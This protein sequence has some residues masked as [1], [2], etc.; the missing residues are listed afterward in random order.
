[1]DRRSFLKGAAAT[2][3]AA[4]PLTAFMARLEAKSTPQGVGYGPLIPTPD[5]TTGLNLL[6]LPEGFSYLSF[7]WTGDLMLNGA[8]TPGSH[9]GMAAFNGGGHRVRLV[10]NHE[11]G[12]RHTLQRRCVRSAAS[13]GRPRSS[14]M[15]R[16][17]VHQRVRQPERHDPQLR[18]WSDAM[19]HL[20]HV[21]R[22]VRSTRRGQA[23][24]LHL[25]GARGRL[26]TRRRSAT[27]A[28]SHTR[29]SPSIRPPAT[30][31]RPRTHGNSSGFYRF[32]PHRRNRPA[33]AAASTCS[34]CGGQPG[35][36]RRELSRTARPSTSSGWTSRRRTILR[37][38]MPGN[39]VWAQ[40]RA[41]GRRDLRRLE[42]CWYGN[43]AKIYVVSTSG[44]VSQGQIWE[45]DPQRGNDR[46]AVPVAGC[47]GAER[48]RQHHRQPARRPR[49]LRGRQ[50]RRV[51]ARPHRRRRD[52]PVRARTA[53]S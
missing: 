27:W 29:R 45:Y 8:L 43:D 2:A 47:G 25:R 13:G 50:R 34:R 1:M 42:G 16:R 15:A 21:R 12:A 28:A 39:F 41:A 19:G 37:P 6:H 51:P 11:L 33:R 48:A 31:T 52:L 53:S 24:R 36:S 14:S 23:A 20:A 3:A 32:V 49:A 35:E 4:V 18:R 30:S 7:S 5:Q 38:T 9:D 17:R 26:A 10:R 40:G 44:G 46:A 22:D